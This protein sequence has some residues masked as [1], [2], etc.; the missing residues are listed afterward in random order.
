LRRGELDPICSL[1]QWLAPANH[2]RMKKTPTSE[3]YAAFIGRTKEAR[4]N[5]KITQRQ[6]ALALGIE[7]PTYKHYEIRSPMP[8]HLLE[9]FSIIVGCDVEYLVT[10]HRSRIVREDDDTGKR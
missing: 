9:R 7:L 10:G 8:N 5:K 4:K 2:R 3:L 1:K 6:V